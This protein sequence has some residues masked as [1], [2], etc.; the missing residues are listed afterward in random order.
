MLIVA[1]FRDVKLCQAP[2]IEWHIDGLW[3]PVR[4]VC[5]WAR[6]I[7]LVSGQATRP[8]RGCVRASKGVVDLEA[9]T[10]LQK[11]DLQTL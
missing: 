1:A 7:Q 5:L 2:S 9:S 10:L 4:M 11:N 6:G 3:T 8:S